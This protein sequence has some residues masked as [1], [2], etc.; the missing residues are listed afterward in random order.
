MSNRICN[1]N[2][3]R[4]ARLSLID[5]LIEA[6]FAYDVTYYEDRILE[7][8]KEVVARTYIIVSECP[9]CRRKF[10]VGDT[11]CNCGPAKTV[12]RRAP[13]KKRVKGIACPQRVVGLSNRHTQRAKMAGIRRFERKYMSAL[14]LLARKGGIPE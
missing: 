7:L 1:K 13:G 2:I 9:L 8:R 14:Q 10:H 6:A 3:E 4:D 5:D 12:S 11:L